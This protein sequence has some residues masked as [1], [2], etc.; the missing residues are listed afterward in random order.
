M[1]ESRKMIITAPQ[2]HALS[3]H[4]VVTVLAGDR[5]IWIT[6]P[7][8]VYMA[9]AALVTPEEIR[10]SHATYTHLRPTRWRVCAVTS[11]HLAFVELEFDGEDYDAEEERKRLNP[12]RRG[13][14]EPPASAMVVSAWARPLATALKLRAAEISRDHPTEGGGFRLGRIVIEF[15]D[16][17]IAP[18]EGGFSCPTQRAEGD[19]DRW[20]DFIA[21]I[22]RGS[23]Y[24]TVELE[25]GDRPV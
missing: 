1:W 23:P 14:R 22:R 3:T 17:T 15:A 25:P 5:R 2:H 24:L 7:Q 16:G 19:S 21:A 6:A 10:G 4:L 8:A 20:D 18:A 12:E 11:T 9:I 13:Y